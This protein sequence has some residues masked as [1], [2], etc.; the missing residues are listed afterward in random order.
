MGHKLPDLRSSWVVIF[1]YLSGKKKGGGGGGG[2]VGGK[3]TSLDL[4][5]SPGPRWTY[6]FLFLI[7]T[8]TSP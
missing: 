3:V 1:V 4:N 8:E 5:L 6:C 2:V 7:E